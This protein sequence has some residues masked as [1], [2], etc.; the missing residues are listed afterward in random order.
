MTVTSQ[1][2]ASLRIC[3]L[4]LDE[5]GHQTL[6]VFF[7]RH[8][9]G[10]CQLAPE[11]EAHA[12]LI[13]GDNYHA[14]K[15]LAEQRESCP[16]RP[17]ILLTLTPEKAEITN[18]IVVQKPIKASQFATQLSTFSAQ[19]F[20]PRPAMKFSA[21]SNGV[22]EAKLK[23]TVTPAA[24]NH[25]KQDRIDSTAAQLGSRERHYYVGSMPDVDLSQASERA[26]VFYDPNDFLQGHF[27]RAVALGQ[28]KACV[29]R[30]IGKSF[31]DILIY[32]FSRRV[33]CSASANIL[34]A[35]ARLPLTANDV[36][37]DLQPDASHMPDEGMPSEPIDAFIWKL[38]LWASRGRLPAGTDLDS[39][40]FV[41]RWPNLTRLL[42]PPNSPRVLGLWSRR[43]YSLKNTPSV[44]GLP[45]R[46]VF[47]LY[48]ACASLEL[49]DITHRAADRLVSPEPP[50]ANE[51]RGL[52]RMLLNKI[53]KLRSDEESQP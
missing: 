33:V 8:L 50:P 19:L 31:Q 1:Q 41:R 25:A 39:L 2:A 17:I 16:D 18:G 47:A 40:A 24:D 30:I 22:L 52:F 45:Q 15:F 20:Q 21:A 49:V 3:P 27:M 29:V 23:S 14:K 48:S 37:I 43:P 32:P 10:I 51:K 4:G 5:R 42:V 28:E 11:T 44:L 6:Q 7:E 53:T 34:Y 36:R 26:K 13:D 35:A 12:V 9:A 38:A 46:Y